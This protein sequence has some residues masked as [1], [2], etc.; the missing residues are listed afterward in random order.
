MIIYQIRKLLG[1][2]LF[3]TKKVKKMLNKYSYNL[4]EN[5]SSK[6]K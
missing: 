2:K 5:E 4:K 6:F 1:L 3:K